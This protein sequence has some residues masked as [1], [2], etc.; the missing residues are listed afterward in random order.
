[1]LVQMSESGSR[2]ILVVAIFS[3]GTFVV[4]FCREYDEDDDFGPAT[5]DEGKSEG[6]TMQKC[7]CTFRTCTHL[8][9]HIQL[10][11]LNVRLNTNSPK[12]EKAMPM[13]WTTFL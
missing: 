2:F 12:T 11:I 7:V 4:S 8:Y 9:I 1:M 3:N 5:A 6:P 13:A 10:Y